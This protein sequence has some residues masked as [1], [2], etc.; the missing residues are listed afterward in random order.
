MDRLHKVI[1]AHIKKSY[2]EPHENILLLADEK[3]MTRCYAMVVGLSYPYRQGEY[4]FSLDIPASFPQKPPGFRAVTWNGVYK[5]GPRICISVGEYHANDIR[6]D[7]AGGHRAARP[8]QSFVVEILNGLLCPEGLGAGIGI[9]CPPLAARQEAADESMTKNR[10]TSRS[11]LAAFEEVAEANP[12]HPA[13]I[14]WNRQR[15]LRTLYATV[16]DNPRGYAQTLCSEFA[17]QGDAALIRRA[18]SPEFVR[19]YVAFWGSAHAQVTTADGVLYRCARELADLD[20]DPYR[21][22]YVAIHRSAYCDAPEA[23]PETARCL[24]AHLQCLKPFEDKLSDATR[25]K[26]GSDRY[27]NLLMA[28][29]T[30]SMRQNFDQLGRLLA[31]LQ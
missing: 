9:S 27:R 17:A 22:A 8:L 12:T 25:V 20:A 4:L 28:I 18:F 30:A 7:G 3:D 5:P 29:L 23:M 1:L 31:A 11:I 15:A 10:E 6:K 13:V 2:G 14:N 21:I 19:W 24:T 16:R 26:W